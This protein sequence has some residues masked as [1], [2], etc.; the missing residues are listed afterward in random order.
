MNKFL[1][2]SFILLFLGCDGKEFTASKRNKVF[3]GDNVQNHNKVNDLSIELSLNV[4]EKK[5]LNFFIET[6]KD[7][8]A[9][10]TS[11][12]NMHFKRTVNDIN[13]I[14]E[15]LEQFFLELK[16]NAKAKELLRIV[17]DTKENP[18][19]GGLE[20][21]K[22]SIAGAFDNFF[23]AT[24]EPISHKSKSIS[25]FESI[26]TACDAYKAKTAKQA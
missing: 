24:P 15:Y 11:S 14:E 22:S 4:D 21:V 3:S 5:T 6:L 1:G 26:K 23:G 18:G 12:T 9:K 2:V 17:K 25:T 16:D 19:V 20:T 7:E 10:T 8:Y 13:K